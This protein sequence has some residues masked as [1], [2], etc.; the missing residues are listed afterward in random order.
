MEEEQ[1]RMIA[2][3]KD[4]MSKETQDLIEAQQSRMAHVIGTLQV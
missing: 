1:E 2:D 4:D 3:M